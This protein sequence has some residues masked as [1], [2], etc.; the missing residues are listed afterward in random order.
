MRRGEVW[1]VESP[2]G[3]G[4]LRLIISGDI[5]NATSVPIVI[6]AEVLRGGLFRDSPLAFAI[7]EDMHVMPDRL[8][9]V[10]KTWLDELVTVLTTKEMARVDHAL[11]SILDLS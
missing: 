8:V 9:W 11:R 1:S 4:S 5:F 2:S 7:D 10:H 6:T 3:R